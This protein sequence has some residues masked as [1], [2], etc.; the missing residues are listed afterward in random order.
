MTSCP[1]DRPRLQRV[2][3][4]KLQDILKDDAFC[5]RYTLL[6]NVLLASVRKFGVLVPVMVQRQN[7]KF[8]VIAGHRRVEAARS[9]KIK[10]VP[11]IEVPG[12]LSARE[13]FTLGLISNWRQEMSEMDR[14]K[15]LG[16]AAGEFRFSREEVLGTIMPLLGMPSDVNVLD[17]YL[18]AD[19][20]PSELKDLFDRRKVPFKGCGALLRFSN[21]DQVLFARRIGAKMQLTSSQIVQAA[22]WLADIM[23]RDGIPLRKLLENAAFRKVLRHP[24]MDPRTRAD[25]FMNAVKRLRYPCYTERNEAFEKKCAPVLRGVPA[26]RIE[27][28]AGF[29]EK[30]FDLHARIKNAGD[31]DRVLQKLS[32]S[33]LELNSLFDFKL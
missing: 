23:K 2:E 13:A 25:Q 5:C 20:M 7:G 10:Q 4:A 32:E 14:A 12:E 3:T 8:R 28:A 1:G 22:E 27:P 17:L 19:G 6:D 31:L 30:G 33:R 26:L 21:P 15:A 11:V 16:R 9:L 29:E 18:K 24:S